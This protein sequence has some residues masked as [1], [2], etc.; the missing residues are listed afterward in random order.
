MLLFI[1]LLFIDD[2]LFGMCLKLFDKMLLAVDVKLAL[3]FETESE[4]DM[5]M[6]VETGGFS[7]FNQYVVILPLPCKRRIR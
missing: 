2:T 5:R 7:P 3:V 4:V 1:D 6:D